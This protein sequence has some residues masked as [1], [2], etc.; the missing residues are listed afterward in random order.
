[1][2]TTAI[3]APGPVNDRRRWF[4]LAALCAAFFMVILDVAI[5]NVA[6]PTIQVDLGFSQKNLQWVVSAYALTFGGLLLLGGR[7]ADL[8]GRRRVFVIGVALFAAASLV[9]GLA[10]SEA[11][12]IAARA[13][14]GVGA[15]LMTPAALSILMTT[16]AEGRERNTALG[17]WGAVGASGGTVGV[18]LGGVFTDTI[19]WEWIFLLNVPV[20]LAVIAV[21]PFLLT[22]SRADSAHRRFDLAG[23]V[24]ITASLALLVYALVEAS[25]EGWG[26]ATTIGRLAASAALM[27]A[28]V[29]IELRSRAP[30]MPFS[31]FR[32]RAVTGSNV[33]GFA[34]GG[35]MFGMF[36]IM[37]LYMQQVAAY[38]PLETGLAYLATSL[39][40][41]IASVGGSVLVTRIGPRVPMVAG[42]LVF[43]VGVLLLAQVPVGGE[44]VADLLPGFLISGFGLGLAFVA[45]SIGALEGV[46]ERDA[47][48]GLR[49]VQHHPADRR[50]ARHGD[51]VDAGD[52]PHRGPARERDRP[53][54]GARPRGSS[55]RCTP[56][57]ASPSWAHS[58]SWR[59]SARSG[60]RRSRRASRS[61]PRGPPPDPRRPSASRPARRGTT[62]RPC[63]PTVGRPPPT[64]G[65]CPRPQRRSTVGV[66]LEGPLE[67][68]S[69]LRTF[70]AF[71]PPSRW[72]SRSSR[73]PP[74]PRRRSI[75]PSPWSRSSPGACGR[76]PACRSPRWPP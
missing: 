33:A 73:R 74:S 19:G 37:T 47:G 42:L 56:P 64:R 11:T 61:P 22:E 34:L 26:S 39:A 21:T 54:A 17:I 51:H 70:A 35:A 65:R 1:M 40:A 12:L 2:S 25:S 46:S 75:W 49:A 63:P 60:A 36:F 66:W 55:W 15:A 5:V 57:W 7:I 43:A 71:F 31:I 53:G 23:G 4:G 3:T 14:Q 58:P 18:L 52:H 67:V 69:R 50:R 10:T 13:A 27:A 68:C 62:R 76:S 59:S 30:L 6:L 44:Y 8:V 72:R 45:F 16:F 28:F 32:I 9:A 48:P 24:T 41:L 38:S 29:V 20:G